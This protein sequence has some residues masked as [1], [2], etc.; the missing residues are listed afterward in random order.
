MEHHA[1]ID[2]A[3][4]QESVDD[5]D[6]WQFYNETSGEE[7][8]PAVDAAG[9]DADKPETEGKKARPRPALAQ[10]MSPAQYV[11]GLKKLG[12]TPSTCGKHLGIS[13]A[14]SFRYSSGSHPIPAVVAKLIRALVKLGSLEV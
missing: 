13:N 1:A 8:G 10:A 7:V 9:P 11:A 2:D 4:A 6:D 14:T 12:L 3:E 5:I